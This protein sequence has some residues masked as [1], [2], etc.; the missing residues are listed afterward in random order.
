M[1]ALLVSGLLCL[2][3]M[4]SFLSGAE[5]ADYRVLGVSESGGVFLFDT[6]AKPARIVQPSLIEN[7]W[8]E[9]IEAAFLHP[10]SECV[11]LTATYHPKLWAV[12]YDG[13][14]LSAR[15]RRTTGQEAEP[16]GLDPVDTDGR[17]HDRQPRLP[18]SQ[19]RTQK[20]G[21]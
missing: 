8:E 13:A 7:I 20:V 17:L 6:A 4:A 3:G 1:R 5:P 15:L 2:C 21:S 14:D 12:G 11:L 19:T 18:P 9:E 10:E 16:A